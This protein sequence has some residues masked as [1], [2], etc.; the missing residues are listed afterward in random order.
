[1]TDVS[2]A[3]F[4]LQGLTLSADEVA[5]F[6]DVRPWGYILFARNIESRD[7][8]RALTDDLRAQSGNP[9]LPILIDQEGGRVARLRPPLV[10]AYPPMGLYGDLY[11][12][13]K[14]LAVEAARL[15]AALLAQDLFEL[16]ISVNCAPCLDLRLP[17]TAE[18]IGDRAFGDDVER[19]VALGRAVM[20]GLEMGGV[21]PVVKHMPGHGRATVD[22]HEELPRIDCESATLRD[23]DFEI[24][25]QLNGALLGM[26]GHLL[27]TA[28]DD[29]AVSTCSKTVI[30]GVIRDHIGFD[31]VLMSDDISMSALAGDMAAR[32]T[33]A[34]KAG[35]DLVLHCNGDM[36]EMQAIAGALPRKPSIDAAPRL[37]KVDEA[38]LS[39][40][41]DVPKGARKVW[42]EIMADIF[43]ESQ[44][45]L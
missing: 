30:G 5:F 17:E 38:L 27:Y 24:F 12:K 16:G 34:L 28:I 40:Q 15:G 33:E 4:G 39:S 1:M 11:A 42:G 36:A 20:D 41:S 9:H 43:P 3:I 31:G 37:K 45:A 26:T 14:A 44:N 25:K 22:S 2:P 35:C 18:I 29:S 13:D 10:S 8:L 7:Q 32:V 6:D 23:S 19:V 21:L